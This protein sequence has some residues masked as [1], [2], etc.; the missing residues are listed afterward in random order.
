DAREPQ[1]DHQSPYPPL[2]VASSLR[3]GHRATLVQAWC[4]TKADRSGHDE[5]P[6]RLA[7]RRVGRQTGTGQPGAL[8]TFDVVAQRLERLAII[9]E[10]AAALDGFVQREALGGVTLG[11]HELY[12]GPLGAGRA[13]VRAPPK[14][15][16]QP[17][18][19]LRYHVDT[20]ERRAIQRCLALRTEGSDAE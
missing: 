10:A 17:R 13:H 18:Q 1:D 4:G 11:Q 6:L 20:S 12:P 19:A 14:A 3:P 2:D 7:Q 16:P 5:A 9:G 8:L 15:S